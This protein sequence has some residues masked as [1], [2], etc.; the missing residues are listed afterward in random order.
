M[1]LVSDKSKENV[2]GAM[3]LDNNGE[4]EAEAETNIYV[5]KN[6]VQYLLGL[7]TIF[8]MEGNNFNK[9][10]LGCFYIASLT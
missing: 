3:V 10:K 7:F 4:R 1:N 2:E 5:C 8:Y 6:I 9:Y